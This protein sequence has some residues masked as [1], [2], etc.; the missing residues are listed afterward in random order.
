MR[1]LSP[2]ERKAVALLML[3]ALVALVQVALV[4]PFV[5]GFAERADERERLAQRYSVN[6][7]LIA[8]I[9]RLRRAAEAQQTAF[10]A[11]GLPAAVADSGSRLLV[12]RL[13]RAVESSG[14][15]LRLAEEA[16][17]GD[18]RAG[19]RLAVRL[20]MEQM[21]RL[22]ALVQDQPPYLAID[23]FSVA[24]DQAYISRKLEPMDVSL[25]VSISLA[26]APAR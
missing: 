12:E 6:Q 13:E 7:R 18:G 14:G 4:G 19:A 21:V 11:L 2:R 1:T 26:R 9:P 8:A 17:P 22:L 20:T 16:P 24:A 10:S 3:V 25:E 23:S 15:E 5:S